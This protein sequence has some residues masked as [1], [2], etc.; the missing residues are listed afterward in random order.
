MKKYIAIATLTLGLV[1]QPALAVIEPGPVVQ[2][3]INQ[4]YANTNAAAIYISFKTPG[5]MPGCYGG[6][7]GYLSHT[8]GNFDRHYAL[9]MTIL[10][11]GSMRGAVLFEKTGADPAVSWGACNIRGLDLRPE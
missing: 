6:V 9:L 4:W 7:G 11:K 5:T 2:L 1:A 8:E 3:S 10:A